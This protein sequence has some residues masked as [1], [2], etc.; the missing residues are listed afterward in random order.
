MADTSTAPTLEFHP[1]TPERWPDLEQLFGPRGAYS[2]CWCTWW[3]LS[4]AEFKRHEPEGRRQCLHD[5]VGSGEVP[6]ILAYV[7]GNPVAWCSIAPRQQYAALERSRVLKRV[8]DAPVWSI[9]CTFVAKPHRRTGM[10]AHLI[11]AAVDYA[12]ERGARIVEAYPLDP[13][14]RKVDTA[15]AY[16]GLLPVFLRAGFVEVARPSERQAIVRYSITD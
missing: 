9:V 14:V 11:H 4:R 8:D 2:G 16:R 7:D 6:G 10:S 5:L 12:A 3:R 13:A 1:V 15:S